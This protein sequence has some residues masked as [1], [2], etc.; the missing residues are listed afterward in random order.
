MIDGVHVWRAALDGSGW[1][2]ASGLPAAER[3]RAA[4]FLRERDSRRWVA[5]RWAL[6]RVLSRYL[7]LPPAEIELELGPHGK[8]R[9]RDHGRLEFNLSHSEGIALVAVADRPVGVDVE[10]IRPGRDTPALA[11]RALPAVDA[12][13]VRAAG[14]EEREL[15]FYRAWARHEARLK[16]LGAALD[17]PASEAQVTVV[18]LDLAPGYAAAVAAAGR[19]PFSPDCRS[20]EPGY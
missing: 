17:A 19:E 7:E 2:A 4:T 20:L 14:P 1:P 10:A 16:C 8:P 15:V 3:E 18:Q 5:S 6:R 11:E 9:L 12:E 13:A